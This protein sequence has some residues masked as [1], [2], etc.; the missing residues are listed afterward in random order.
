M[1]IYHIVV[2]EVWERA[3][4]S[5]EYR[6]ESFDAEGFIHCSFA[7]QIGPVIERYYS[8]YDCVTILTIDSDRLTSR[9]E[10]EP[11]TNNE[12]YPHIYGGINR[13]AVVGTE[14]RVLP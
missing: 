12:I 2:P 9:L 11:S 7:G 3:A 1:L 14:V 13:D 5:T 4:N 6:P 10:L 8:G